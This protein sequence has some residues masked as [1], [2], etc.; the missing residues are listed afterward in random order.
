MIKGSLEFSDFIPHRAFFNSNYYKLFINF[1]FKE[2][3]FGKHLIVKL[4]DYFEI[5]YFPFLSFYL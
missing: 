4:G 3:L 5:A 1:N 2:F